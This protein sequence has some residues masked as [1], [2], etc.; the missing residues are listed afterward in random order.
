MTWYKDL[1]VP[2]SFGFLR[3]Q[4][5]P[6]RIKT[7]DN[8]GEVYAWH[9]LPIELY[10][11]HESTLLSEP[12][13]RISEMSTRT[14]F[15]LLRDDPDA[16]LVI[17]FHGAAGTVG[18]GYRV[19]NY[20]ALS[21]GQPNRIHILSFDY[22]GFGYSKGTPSEHGLCSDAISVVDWAIGVAKIPPSRILIFG[23]SIGTA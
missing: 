15:R 23:Q 17:H 4:V 16:L 20:R 9:I 6:F 22:R 10:R 12:S 3:N 1:N 2:E 8:G 19:P 14:A 5:T 13:G 7:P 18:S 11:Q 21:A